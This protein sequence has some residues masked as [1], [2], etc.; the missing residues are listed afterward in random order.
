[1]KIILLC[2]CILLLI[3]ASSAAEAASF[4][5]LTCKLSAFYQDIHGYWIVANTSQYNTSIGNTDAGTTVV[6]NGT[7]TF[8][9]GLICTQ[10]CDSI[11]IERPILVGQE[12]YVGLLIAVI[13]MS[14]ALAVIFSV[15]CISCC[16][17]DLACITFNANPYRRV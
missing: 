17:K 12:A 10:V 6:Q 16:D 5:N 11:V 3:H 2:Y 14:I 1:M 8:T 9:T 13:F 7:L 4:G 15:V